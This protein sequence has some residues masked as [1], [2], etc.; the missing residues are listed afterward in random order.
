MLKS[1]AYPPYVQAYTTR[2]SIKDV[3]VCLVSV[4]SCNGAKKASRIYCVSA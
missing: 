4:T 2:A 3:F 1:V